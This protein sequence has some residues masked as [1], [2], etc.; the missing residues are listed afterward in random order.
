M[1]QEDDRL[2]DVEELDEGVIN[3]EKRNARC[4]CWVGTWNNPAMT[5]EE[6]E[7]F[8][9]DLEQQDKIKYACGQRE[10][11]EVSKIEHFQFFVDF[12]TPQ[13][14]TAVKTILPYGC[15][16][17]PMISTKERCQAYCTKSD[18]RIS[19]NF[20]EVGEFISERQRTDLSKAIKMIDDGFSLEDIAETFPNQSVQY[21]RQLQARFWERQEKKF[22]NEFRS[23]E[24]TYIYGPP[25]LGKSTSVYGLVDK[26]SD[27][28]SVPDYGEYWFT[29]YKG[30][31]I[32][33]LDEFAGQKPI[34]FMNKVLDKLPLSL[35]AKGSKVVACYTK[36]FIVSNS[37]LEDIYKKA[38]DENPLLVKAFNRR[39]NKIIRF[40]DFDKFV[41]ERDS[42]W[43][44][45]PPEEV[46]FKGFTRQVKRTFE[47]DKY[48][49]GKIIFDREKGYQ[50]QMKEI[51][52]D[53]LPW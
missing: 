18:T 39:I 51:E 41:I 20:F 25:G 44:D 38:Q 7:K 11:G 16:F 29:G 48:G 45:I 33:M 47:Y 30:Q 15:H 8:F 27:I 49:L 40:T 34:V 9:V 42:E 3:A 46:K 10:L 2:F 1:K 21:S 14:F 22:L 52:E 37:P 28:F 12:K 23:I 24:V 6:F 17:K 32:I 13:R 5:D 4:C 50:E 53:S 31:D 36:V 43:E 35:N 26:I 19:V